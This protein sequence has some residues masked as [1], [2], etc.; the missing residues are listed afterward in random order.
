MQIDGAFIRRSLTDRVE[1]VL[2]CYTPRWK[3]YHGAA[4]PVPGLGADLGSF[5]VN[6]TGGRRGSWWRFSQDVGG[7]SVELLAYLLTGSPK[8]YRD[9]FDE[10]RRFLGITNGDT[11]QS[12][13]QQIEVERSRARREEAA[14][15][16]AAASEK[17]QDGVIGIDRALQPPQ[18]TIVQD[19]LEGRRT[20]LPPHAETA[21]GFHPGLRHESGERFPAMVGKVVDIAGELTGVWRTW[22][23]PLT[24]GKADV[25]N[26][27]M[28]LG[29]TRGGAV[30]LGGIG[31]RIAVAEGIETACAV[32]NL[33]RWKRPVWAALSTSGMAALEIPL[34][35][36]HVSIFPDG[37]LPIRRIPGR[38]E[39]EP[40]PNPPGITAAR[41]LSERL[42]LAGIKHVINTPPTGGDYLDCL[43]SVSA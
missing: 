34:G 2:D 39:W 42:K 3:Q 4:Y 36:E 25:V 14:R 17:R 20:G 22:I 31:P 11:R 5:R 37:D 18:S 9:A 8:S 24:A 1:Q 32:G 29:A 28:G 41:K 26:Q 35:V 15:E 19:Y 23:D 30:R 38:D 43:A 16:E 10:A 13:A 12:E 27:K 40:N 7:G 21:I 6:L 33:I